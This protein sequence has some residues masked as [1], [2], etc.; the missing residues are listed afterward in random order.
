LVEFKLVVSTPADGKSK[1]VTA[2]D[3]QAQS[4]IGMRIGDTLSGEQFG[5]SGQELVITGGSDKSGV[6]LRSD[7]SGG[8]KRKILLSGPPGYLPKSD[9][10][11]K[12]KLVRGNMITEDMVQI[13]LMVKKPEEADKKGE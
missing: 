12:R 7:I 13:N 6:P 3:A 2:T 9:G 1:T 10:Q 5:L 4:L 11:R 8:G